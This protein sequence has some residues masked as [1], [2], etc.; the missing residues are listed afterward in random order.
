[1]ITHQ[2]QLTVDFRPEDFSTMLEL[3]YL[4]AKMLEDFADDMPFGR[5]TEIIISQ[6]QLKLLRF[7]W[8]LHGLPEIACKQWTLPSV[9]GVCVTVSAFEWGCPNCG[10]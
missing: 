4:T 1:M 3:A 2:P 9:H 5:V 8:Y 7:D 6:F 10:E